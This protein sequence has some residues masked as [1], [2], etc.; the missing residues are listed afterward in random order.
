VPLSDF[1]DLDLGFTE[2]IVGGA[3]IPSASIDIPVKVKSVEENALGTSSAPTKTGVE[4]CVAA[5]SDS[6]AADVLRTFLPNQFTH[7]YTRFSWS[8]V[9]FLFVVYCHG[10]LI[11]C[12]NSM[13]ASAEGIDRFAC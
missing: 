1:H 10:D 7:S 8:S 4:T 6:I 13:A 12:C 11:G 3:E 9:C 2:N 5:F